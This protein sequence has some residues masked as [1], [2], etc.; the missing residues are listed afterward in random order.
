MRM[1]RSFTSRG[2]EELWLG[3]LQVGNVFKKSKRNYL[4]PDKDMLPAVRG[5][6]KTKI[7]ENKALGD[8]RTLNQLIENIHCV[9]LPANIISVLGNAACIK[10]ISLDQSLMERFSINLYHLLRNEFICGEERK[11]G[12]AEKER[13][14]KR[15]ES[16]LNLITELQAN[17]QQG[18]PVIGR[19]L[20][21]YLEVWDGDSHFTLIIRLISQL[22]ISDYKEV[23]D[24]VIE[25]LLTN[26]F[27][28]YS[29]IKQICV[30]HYLHS[31]L[32]LWA[33]LE[34]DRFENHRR[35]VF[36]TNTIN[37]TNPLEAIYELSQTI[38]EWSTL[39]LALSRQNVESTHLLTSLIMMQYKTSQKLMMIHNVPIRLELPS[40]YLYDSL[41]SHSADLLAMSCQ[42]IL[43]AKK[44]VLP[45]MKTALRESEQENGEDHVTTNI[46]EKMVS[47]ESK[48]DL[49][50]A[51]RDYLVFLSPGSVNLTPTSLLRQGWDL[52]EGEEHLKESLFLTSHPAMLPLALQ[53]V[54]S[55]NLDEADKQTAWTQLSQ[56]Q[57]DS[58]AWQANI[59]ITEGR[60]KIG[61]SNFYSSKGSRR[62]G[63]ATSRASAS[64]TPVLGNVMDFLRLL[65][66]HLPPITDL[67][68]EYYQKSAS[69]NAL[70]PASISSNPK[71]ADLRSI[72][73]QQT[74]DS[75]VESL[76]PSERKRRTTTSSELENSKVSKKPRRQTSTPVHQARKKT[77]LRGSRGGALADV[78]NNVV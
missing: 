23:F 70:P 75:G 51:T 53:F 7:D 6:R 65:S 63:P 49:L 60:T 57:E 15:R 27:R 66:Q 54:D 13:K 48:Q 5:G 45:M 17:V 14:Y 8:L 34:L 35:T 56:E 11:V 22:Q 58:E 10:I 24:C 3:G 31:L 29:Q 39:S 74:E 36:P 73:S 69:T 21:E 77:R 1:D 42:Y 26:H 19:W 59:S 47:D 71:E 12:R 64:A 52:P 30:L 40:A 67:I 78:S 32:R 16:I 20:T 37:C 43:T 76:H 2:T 46:I 68:M 38:N 62:S 28:G 9:Q 44:Q 25:P 41:F 72:I 33:V 55:L 61:S 18:L 4:L 50:A